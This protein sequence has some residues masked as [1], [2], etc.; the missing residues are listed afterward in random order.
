MKIFKLINANLK[1]YFKDIPLI[2]N[3]ILVPFVIIMGLNFLISPSVDENID[4]N[5]SQS[6]FVLN[7]G[8]KYESKLIEKY[9]I[10]DSNIFRI[11]QKTQAVDQLKNNDFINV[12][13]F[14]DNY[15]K[16]IDYDIKPKVES[17][18]INDSRSSLSAESELDSFINDIFKN[19]LDPG[20][21]KK[22]IKSKIIDDESDVNFNSFF[23]IFMICYMMFITST[24]LSKGYIELK[25]SNILSRLMS[26]GNRGYEI[27]FS[28]F[29]SLFLVQAIVYTAL[30]FLISV[31]SDINLNL[32]QVLL[33]LSNC[34]ASTGFILF[35]V[36]I[37]KNES[38]VPAMSMFAIF[39]CL[40]SMALYINKTITGINV[41]LLNNI[42]KLT[43]FYWT[44]DSLINP[45]NI[46]LNMIPIIL[47]GL[48]FITAGSLRLRDFAKN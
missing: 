34:F 27:M 38:S 25:S 4:F 36:R 20:L 1:R 40:I 31:I 32:P 2:L 23:A 26:T 48:A 15:S 5:F 19:K 44:L 24:S 47:I 42:A 12:F 16:E 10:K 8:G 6:A 17:I 37:F 11:N 3:I 9:N 45:S 18:K 46:N 13:I 28:L 35:L 21:N 30:L 7:K 29:F 14:S 41:S 22:E 43:P 33:V 39:Y